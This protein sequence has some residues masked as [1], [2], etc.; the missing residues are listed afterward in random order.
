M[1]RDLAPVLC[2]YTW[3]DGGPAVSTPV[4]LVAGWGTSGKGLS[5]RSN[6]RSTFA[7]PGAG[8]PFRL[9]FYT[10]P[11]LRCKQVGALCPFLL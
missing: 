4:P 3:G 9:F 1:G 7:W 5:T 11:Y 8:T 2:R 10:S 6:S